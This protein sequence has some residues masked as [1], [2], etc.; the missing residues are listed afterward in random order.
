MTKT[1]L[2]TGSSRGIGLALAKQYQSDG[3]NVIGAA[4]NPSTAE[5]LQALKPYKV[6]QLDTSDEDSVLRAAKDLEDEAIDVIINNAGIAD[7]YETFETMT[8]ESMMKHFEVNTVGSFL[9]SRAFVPHLKAA[10]S[11]NGIAKLVQI[12]SSLGS[13]TLNDGVVGF[14]S[15]RV[16]KAA[17]NM[18]HMN[19]THALKGE[20]IVCATFEPGHVA[21]DMTN[22]PPE[23]KIKPSLQPWESA[24]GVSK[25]IAGLTLND[26]GGY[27]DYLGERLPW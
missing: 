10:V 25:V 8:K 16:S 7:I 6:V 18:A 14:P 26:M 12:S 3:W 11:K 9:V 1:V 21:T 19:I 17:L 13:I 20:N 22:Y 27:F 2:I 4:R 23:L 15:Y 5:K 24:A